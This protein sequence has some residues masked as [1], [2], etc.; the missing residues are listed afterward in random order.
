M[1]YDMTINTELK[2]QLEEKYQKFLETEFTVFDIET[3]GLDPLKDEVL[4]IAG[5]KMKGPLEI[6]RFEM[7]LRPT[8]SIPPEVEKIHG[9]N[10]FFLLV[11]GQDGREVIN[12]FLKFIKDSI[13]VGHNIIGFDWLFIQNYSKKYSFGLPQN[14]LIDTLLLARKILVLPQYN[15]TAV[16][17]SFGFENRNAHR[18]M[19]DVEVNAQVFVKL[20]EKMFGVG[21]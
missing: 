9:L 15:L 2:A 7:L 10:E 11:N 12:E 19:P 21:G 20:M 4:E 16:A 6:D 1:L 18:A 5:L 14:N 13:V 17:R 3:S 8:R